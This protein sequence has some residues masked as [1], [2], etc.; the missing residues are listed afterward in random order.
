MPEDD[1]RLKAED[2]KWPADGGEMTGY[3]VHPADQTG[4]LPTV[5]VVHENRGLNAHITDVARRVALEGFV[6][7]GAGLSCRRSAARQPTRTRPARCSTSSTRSSRW[8]MASP[9]SPS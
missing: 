4:K 5:I 7:L 8:P 2:V 9:R 1:Q 3:L 6:A